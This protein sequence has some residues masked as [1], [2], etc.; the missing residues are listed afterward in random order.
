MKKLVAFLTV[1]V[2]G[3]GGYFGFDYYIANAEKPVNVKNNSEITVDIPEGSSTDKIATVLSEKNLIKDKNVFKYS[4]K[5]KG[6]DSKFKA[7][8]Y[9]LRQNMNMNEISSSI[10]KGAIKLGD[11][12]FTVPE[13]YE[14]RQIA[15]ILSKDSIVNRERFLELTS[16][17]DNFKEKYAFLASVPAGKGLEGYLYPDT[18]RIDK[19]SENREE[20]IIE[21]M[22]DNFEKHY[23]EELN[24]K[25]AALGLDT[26]QAITLAS[27]VEREAQAE[28][29]RSLVSAVFHNRIKEGMGLQSCAT[30][31][32]ILEERKPV[33]SYEDTKIDSP[34][35]T[36]IHPGLPPA[37]IA[38]PGIESLIAALNPEDVDYMY[39]V[40]KGDGSHAF[41]TTYEEHLNAQNND[42]N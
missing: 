38:S 10:T 34:Y 17:A 29:E 31:Q 37:P 41:S 36:Y 6:M 5:R 21:M 12:G 13:G 14:I 24:A 25:A 11:Y 4:A 3:V 42:Q 18:Y 32:Y 23:T 22:L 16:N 33:L 15:D 2:I 9:K 26:N 1:I 27:I 28:N 40:A 30:V 35:N 39:F 8:S 19:T 20:L 7:G